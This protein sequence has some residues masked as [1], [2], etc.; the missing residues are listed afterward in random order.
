MPKRVVDGEGLWRSDKLSMIEPASRRAEY[1]NLLPLALSNGVFEANPRRIWATVYSYNRPDVT[2]EDVVEILDEF[3][4][5]KLLFR[6][7]AAD[8]K[9]WGYWTGIEK[10]GR[11]PGVSRRGKNEAIGPEPPLDS[12]RKVLDSNGIHTET[13]EQP[14]G[15]DLRLGLGLGFGLG[16]GGGMDSNGIHGSLQDRPETSTQEHPPESFGEQEIIPAGLSQVEYARKLL[17]DLGL[18]FTG[19]L[20]LVADSIFADAKKHGITKAQSYEFI[21]RQALADQEEGGEINRFYWTDAKFR[22]VVNQRKPVVPGQDLVTR[23]MAQLE[24]E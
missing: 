15:T 6:W 19:N 3:E 1:A 4:R 24:A 11:L 22:R 16:L 14:R 12:I 17:E 23:T 13:I 9:V 20:A 5:V 21:R 2:L 8:G 7:T 18:P 10:P